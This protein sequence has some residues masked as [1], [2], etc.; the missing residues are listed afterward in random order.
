MLDFTDNLVA[1]GIGKLD[2]VVVDDRD[3]NDGQP[4]ANPGERVG[5]SIKAGNRFKR[6]NEACAID[7]ILGVILLL[8]YE[9]VTIDFKTR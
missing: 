1:L 7:G 6:R 3:L 2:K 5:S 9:S 8:F 4:L